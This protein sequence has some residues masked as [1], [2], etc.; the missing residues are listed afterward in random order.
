[1]PNEERGEHERLAAPGDGAGNDACDKALGRVRR[2]VLV[3]GGT[4][5]AR[6][7]SSLLANRGVP[8]IYSLAG[9]TAR[10]RSP[11]KGVTLRIGGFG[12]GE[13]LKRYL[14]EQDVAVVIDATH[15]F[16]ARMQVHAAEACSALGLSIVRLHRHPWRPQR[17]D[18]WIRVSS[19]TNAAEI[20]PESA[21]VFAALGARGLQGL[22]CRR[23][24]H[25]A[26]RMLSPPQWSLPPR[27]R[28]LL[29]PPRKTAAQEAALLR[30]LRMEWLICRNAGGAAGL[31][32]LQAARMCGLPVIMIEPP[33]PLA[34]V[35]RLVDIASLLSW[36]LQRLV[37]E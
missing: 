22:T 30:S 2:S 31:P 21:R 6:K 3:L 1:M 19:I 28:I 20:L 13:G 5:E 10:P 29:A 23:D 27:W 18:R 12:G 36:T 34:G 14:V 25:V 16:A 37:P 9:V 33:P 11:G 24:L 8:V 15:P 4:E 26:A 17:D 7:I 35:P 32:R